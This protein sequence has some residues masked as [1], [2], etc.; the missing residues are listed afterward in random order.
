MV[1]WREGAAL[2]HLRLGDKAAAR[3]LAADAVQ[4]AQRF[5]A[6]RALGYALRAA[7][8]V[9]D[10]PARIVGLGQAQAELEAA[11]APLELARVSCELGAAL[12]AAGRRS[13]A[14]TQLEKAYG[15]ANGIGAV[16]VAERTAEELA[17]VGVRPRREP[18]TGLAALTPSE[19]RV[20][21]LASAGKTNREIAES[22]FITQK[23]VETHLGHVYDKL[24]VR[25]RHKLPDDL[26]RQSV[27]HQSEA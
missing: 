4:R 25:S 16:R 7:A 8:L 19:R 23:T 27:G 10:G 2:A 17:A 11:N 18:A 15:L 3:K 20:A 22:L 6:R 1:P 26:E 14:R 12:R 24:G 9:E 5:G 21:E 13:D